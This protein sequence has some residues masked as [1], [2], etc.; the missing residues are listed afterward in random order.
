MSRTTP[1]VPTTSARVQAEQFSNVNPNILP[2]NA[3]QAPH[4]SSFVSPKVSG[5]THSI[6]ASFVFPFTSPY[7]FLILFPA[8][9]LTFLQCSHPIHAHFP[10]IQRLEI[11]PSVPSPHH[12]L[13][14]FPTSASTTSARVLA[15]SLSSYILSNASPSKALTYFQVNTS[16]CS[17]FCF[18][19]TNPFRFSVLPCHVS[20]VVSNTLIQFAPNSQSFLLGSQSSVSSHHH[21]L[22]S[23]STSRFNRICKGLGRPIRKCQPKH[24]PYQTTP[25]KPTLFSICAFHK[26]FR[27]THPITAH[28]FFPCKFPRALHVSLFPLPSSLFLVFLQCS[29]STP[30]Q[31][32]TFTGSTPSLLHVCKGYVRVSSPPKKTTTPQS[33]LLSARA[34]YWGF[35]ILF[36]RFNSSVR[37]IC[38]SFG[39]AYLFR[40]SLGLMLGRL[41]LISEMTL[42]GE[43]VWEML[44]SQ[45]PYPMCGNMRGSLHC[46]S[47]F[48]LLL[49]Y[50]L[51]FSLSVWV[52]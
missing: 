37:D 50:Y 51:G 29:H 6:T 19:F 28:L 3:F 2:N 36:F 33:L 43:L 45:V 32:S 40:R 23:R 35:L 44:L 13:L 27:S 25:S 42:C 24:S 11:Y 1:T 47:L 39:G 15:G 5:P 18:T 38:G 16:D 10:V 30:I 41:I 46:C 14:S 8:I 20:C 34:K 48:S 9:P 22:L 7:R 26:F 31:S 17:P 52:I 12:S 4:H 21:F 49:G